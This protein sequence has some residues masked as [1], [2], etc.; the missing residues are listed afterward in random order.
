MALRYDFVA[1]FDPVLVALVLGIACVAKVLGCALGARLGGVGKREAFAIGFGMN[2]RGA[3]E[4]LLAVIALEAKIIN[5]QLF[6][7]LVVMAVVTSLIS[8]PAMARLLRA[9]WSPVQKLLR[10]GAIRLD[11]PATSRK[12]AIVSLTSALCERIGRPDDAQRFADAVL[13]REETAGTGVGEGVAFPHAEAEGL[14]EPALAFGRSQ[15]G[16]DFD[17]PDGEPAKLVFL[18]LTPRGDYEGSLHLLAGMARLLALEEVRKSLLTASDP[19]A[20]LNAL[21]D[22]KRVPAARKSASGNGPP[23]RS[24]P[25]AQAG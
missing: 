2:S 7:A 20:I 5:E 22:P 17:S 13:S 8:G 24:A 19:A 12:D 16:L 11:L 21:S 9:T 25:S 15:A 1:S 4:I 18:L 14:T 23:S 3:M 6:V 10:A